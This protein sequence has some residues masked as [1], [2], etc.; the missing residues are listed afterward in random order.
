MKKSTKSNGFSIFKTSYVADLLLLSVAVIWGASYSLAKGALAFTPVMFFLVLRFG[1]TFL[2]L[3]PFTYKELYIAPRSSLFS[4]GLLGLILFSIF[5]CETYGIAYTSA[6]NAAFLISLCVVFT[7]IV[8]AL[9]K[10][11][12][13]DSMLLVATGI[14][15]LGTWFMTSRQALTFN[16]GDGL[17]LLA[18]LFRALMVS[19][20]KRVTNNHTLSS[21]A[22]TQIQMGVVFIGSLMAV[23]LL[24][25]NLSLPTSG[26]F[27]VRL[28]FLVLFCTL[29]AFF[30]Q[31]YGVKHTN[32]T[33]ASFLMGTEPLFGAVFAIY[34]L[35]EPFSFQLLVGGGLITAGTYLGMK[36]TR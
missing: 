11:S 19:S 31:N 35:S 6:S 10:K 15:V 7:P 8:D 36:M 12:I 4:G 16:V 20:I 22:L 14:C 33:R 27:W 28:L 26:G 23:F 32:P 1:L 21:M 9:L 24:G 34:L 13:P 2:V 30:A 18:A 5:L 29:F 3:I 25:N 17:I